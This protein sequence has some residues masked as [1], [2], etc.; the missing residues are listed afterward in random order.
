MSLATKTKQA[1]DTSDYMRIADARVDGDRLIVLFADH[2]RA[3]VKLNCLITRRTGVRWD[4]MTFGPYELVIPTNEG[5]AEISWLSIRDL[6]DSAF[7]AHLDAVEKKSAERIGRQIRH[8]REE[9][10]L[11]IE[12]LALAAGVDASTLSRIE[13][14]SVDEAFSRLRQILTPLGRTLKDLA[15]AAEHAES[16]ADDE[17]P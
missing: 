15:L 12:D 17:E 10:Q 13:Q 1:W 2:T 7:A 14:G 9:N 5:P 11:S 3:D 4:R 16:D 6:T 8:W